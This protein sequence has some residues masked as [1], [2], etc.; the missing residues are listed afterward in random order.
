MAAST[1]A[2]VVSLQFTCLA[3]VG[4]TMLEWKGIRLLERNTVSIVQLEEQIHCIRSSESC[5]TF[6]AELRERWQPACL[7]M[8]WEGATNLVEEVDGWFFE[9][10]PVT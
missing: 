4:V 2:I 6:G 9:I 1:K 10:L 7:R 3:L 8:K 5:L